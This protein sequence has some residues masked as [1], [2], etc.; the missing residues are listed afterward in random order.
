[1]A[2]FDLRFEPWIPVIKP[3]GSYLNLGF[4]DLLLQAE[5]ISEIRDPIPLVEF[6]LYRLLTALV[7]DIFELGFEN[8][9]WHEL[10]QK[11]RFSS[12]PVDNY[13]QRWN[14]RFDLFH[15]KFPFL[16]E[17]GMRGKNLK[18][19]ANLLPAVPTGTNAFVFHHCNENIFYVSPAGAARLLT[20][21]APFM[22]AGGAGLS[23]SINGAPPWYILISGKSV[24]HT[25]LLNSY[26][27]YLPSA[28]P[29]APPAWRDERHFSDGRRKSAGLLESLTWRPRKILF[30]P[31]EGGECSFLGTEKECLIREMFFEKN[32]A[33]DFEWTDPAVPY[34]ISDK[35]I[36][37]RPQEGRELWRDLG[38][39]ALLKKNSY[40]SENG[41]IQF[42]R[43]LLI[44][45]LA[46]FA[47]YGQI[48]S[49][50]TVRLVA[51]GMRTDMKMKI[52]EWQRE[53]L[54]L[55]ASL[56]RLDLNASE[57]QRAMDKA[58]IVS[59][60]LRQ[61]IKKN[62]PRDGASNKNPLNTIITSAQRRFWADLKPEYERLL[63]ALA[64][65]PCGQGRE[66]AL[67][68]AKADWAKAAQRIGENSLEEAIRDLDTDARALARQTEAR[69]L[70][71]NKTYRLFN[72]PSK[73]DKKQ[74]KDKPTQSEL[75]FEEEL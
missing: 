38:P 12:E 31:E 29:N 2:D 45:Q 70:Y 68:Q 42:D 10:W 55:P 69:S 16:Q 25:I 60:Y 19:V 65:L 67:A 66:E 48:Q 44:N 56:L 22:T 15:S 23:P 21:V 49:L 20:T 17:A 14:D 28:V 39:I 50:G 33:C 11:G 36:P 61:A 53:T 6:G 24:F 71:R 4:R 46:D 64:A 73:N 63:E 41:K 62:F 26:V 35:H 47:A 32:A 52:F 43:P 7:M 27:M 54:T 13:F 59:L 18:P 72:P 75:S 74:K 1:M 3:D 30:K 37:L 40:T 58:E 5:N 34:K 8:E 57:A 51:Y 9:N